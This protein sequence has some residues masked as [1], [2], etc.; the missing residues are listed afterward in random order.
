MSGSKLRF[1]PSRV[2]DRAFLVDAGTILVTSVA[3]CLAADR[4]A[5]MSALVPLILLGRFLLWRGPLKPEL[6]FFGVCLILGAFNDWNSVVNHRI[7]DYG[8]PVYWPSLSTIPL[9]MLLFWG[10]ILRFFATLAQW[11]RLGPS[12]P[13]DEVYLGRRV[14]RSPWLRIGVLLA[15]VALTRQL[16]YRHFEHPILS[17]LPFAGALL[18]YALLMRPDR[19]D[20]RL[21]LVF[22]IGGPLVEVLYIQVAGLHRYSLGWLGGVPLWIALWWVLAVLV[23][24]DLA[25]RIQQAFEAWLGEPAVGGSA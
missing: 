22:L 20:R 13:R 16:I 18:L 23:W 7:Y 21:V 14:L 17:W 9:W 2:D 11:E 24:K 4:L 12:P 3:I 10:M 19:H 6:A 15:I 25:G 8:V 1:D 5:L